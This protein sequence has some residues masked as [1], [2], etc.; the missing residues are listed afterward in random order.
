MT[1]T[2]YECVLIALGIHHAGHMHHLWPAQLYNIYPHY[3]INGT[4]FREK[5]LSIKCVFLFSLQ[6]LSKT[7]LILGSNE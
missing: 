5:L 6:L 2:Y 4:I 7:F 1:T 3:L